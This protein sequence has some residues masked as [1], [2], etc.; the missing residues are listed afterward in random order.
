MDVT[1]VEQDRGVEPALVEPL[2]KPPL[3][4]EAAGAGQSEG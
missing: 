3:P 4:R 2:A 1:R